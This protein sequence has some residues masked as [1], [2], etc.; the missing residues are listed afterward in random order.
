M[1]S[2]APVMRNMT[3]A[4]AQMDGLM[5]AVQNGAAADF[6]ADP[7]FK[8][9][10]ASLQRSAGQ[11][12]P[13]FALARSR[14]TDTQSAAGP[15]LKRMQGNAERLS[16][17]FGQILAMMETENG[18]FHRMRADSALLKSLHGAKAQL[19]SLLIEA[20]KNPLKFVM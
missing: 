20:K 5:E 13:A 10:L 2:L 1:A 12:G 3:T 6:M 7:A 19:D 8:A 9:D 15:S 17:A 14:L 16:A 11:L 4:Q 18:T